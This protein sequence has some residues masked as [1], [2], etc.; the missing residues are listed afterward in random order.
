[1][2]VEATVAVIAASTAVGVTVARVC[3]AGRAGASTRVL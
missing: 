3:E 1:L 2:S